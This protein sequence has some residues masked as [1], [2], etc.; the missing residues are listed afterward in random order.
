MIL[1]MDLKLHSVDCRHVLSNL[2]VVEYRT[3]VVGG[4]VEIEEGLL[5]VDDFQL[6]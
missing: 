3:I 4:N 5:D 6:N 2:Q 1:E